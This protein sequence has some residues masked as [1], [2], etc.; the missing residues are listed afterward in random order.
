[1]EYYI[2]ARNIP[3]VLKVEIVK[4]LITQLLKGKLA[5]V[6]ETG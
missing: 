3:T 6:R 5:A 4:S 1:M 2:G